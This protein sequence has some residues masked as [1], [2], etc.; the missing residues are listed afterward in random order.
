MAIVGEEKDNRYHAH[1]MWRG[2]FWDDNHAP[3][4]FGTPRCS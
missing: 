3:C 4:K 2:N 1:L